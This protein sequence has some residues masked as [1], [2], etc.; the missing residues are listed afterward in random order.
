MLVAAGLLALVRPALA[1]EDATRAKLDEMI[2]AHAQENGIPVGLVHRVVQRESRYHP[3]LVGKGGAIGLMQIKLA[4]ARGLGYTGTARGLLDPET[5]L[6]YA[7]RYLAG[8]YQV[9]GGNENRAV[10]HYARGYYYA[11]KRKGMLG[12]LATK[13]AGAPLDISPAV[14]DEDLTSVQHAKLRHRHSHHRRSHL[15]RRD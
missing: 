3:G 15:A 2:A 6:T 7:V 1:Q 12:A 10:S 5:N 11:A 14:V 9:A 8:A 4:T 13:I